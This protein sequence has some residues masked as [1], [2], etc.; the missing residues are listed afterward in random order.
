[1]AERTRVRIKGDLLRWAMIRSGL[2]DEELERR[3]PQF[4]EWEAET[5]GPTLRQLEQF[6]SVTRTPL[7]YLFLESPPEER[8][9]IRHFRT[10]RDEPVER[11]SPDL[12]ET[13]QAMQRRQTWMR[14][15]LI[16]E[17]EVPLPF[18]GSVTINTE[19][20][21]T[22]EGIRN[23]L[24]LR[25]GWAQRYNWWREAFAALRDS[26]DQAG[27][28]VIK[29]GVVGNNTHRKLDVDEFRGFVLVDEYAPLVFINGADF[30]GAQM[31]T[32][33]HEL[34]HVW[35][36]TSSA[37]N[38][39]DLQPFDEEQEKY[40]NKVAAEFLVPERELRAAWQEAD[41]AGG[42]PFAFLS[43]R[44]KVSSIV[45]ARRALDLGFISRDRFF[46]FLRRYRDE[47]EERLRERRES[48]QPGGNFYNTQNVRIG[49]RFA[50]AVY[51]AAKDGR[52][53]YRDAFRL[54]G[55]Y[56]NTFDNYFRRLG[57]A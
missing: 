57:M 19:I 2:T 22:A 10:I 27:I 56:G 17:K 42:D 29:N 41:E 43:R 55:L 31:F 5:R 1:M 4:V 8:L 33:A 50:A 14:E 28:L 7:G 13:V 39:L 18:V 44:F 24:G 32:L 37:F 21:E 23:V 47:Q 46:E 26:T 3:F 53:L 35:L 36:G 51:H 20:G 6:A 45:V 30:E 9:P 11:P 12:L 40:C 52:I 16:E 49:K 25:T 15:F 54:T 48:R 34:A 38:L